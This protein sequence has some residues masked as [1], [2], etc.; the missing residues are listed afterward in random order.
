MYRNVY[1][2]FG[3]DRNKNVFE[4]LFTVTMVFILREILLMILNPPL[5]GLRY[6]YNL[7]H[8]EECFSVSGIIIEL[9]KTIKGVR[10]SPR[11][12]NRIIGLYC[13]M[14]IFWKACAIQSL[15]TMPL[16]SWKSIERRSY[17]VLELRK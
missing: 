4:I 7:R 2:E 11:I 16:T 15:H 12:A 13:L 5:M 17:L 9:I 3:S 6:I 1:T 10:K 14:T 8:E